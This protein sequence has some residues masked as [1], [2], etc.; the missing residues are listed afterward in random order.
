MLDEDYL[1]ST[2]V[3]AYDIG[4][5]VV[6]PWIPHA[7]IV[8]AVEDLFLG[9]GKDFDQQTR[10]QIDVDGTMAR[11]VGESSPTQ[12]IFTPGDE[13]LFTIDPIDRPMVV[14]DPGGPSVPAGFMID[15]GEIMHLVVDAA[16]GISID[17]LDHG[18]HKWDTGFDVMGTFGYEYEDVDALEAVGVLEGTDIQTPEPSTVVICGLALAAVGGYRMR[19]RG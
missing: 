5:G 2:S 18:G 19:R 13:L 8:E 7:V 11:D 9:P 10:N 6:A 12:P 17:F 15:G 16:G 14:G 1:T 4:T 3:W